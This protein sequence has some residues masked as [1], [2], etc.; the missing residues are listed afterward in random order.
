[1]PKK[2]QTLKQAKSRERRKA[3]ER[4]KSQRKAKSLKMTPKALLEQAKQQQTKQQEE[5]HLIEDIRLR[6]MTTENKEELSEMA[7]VNWRQELD[8]SMPLED[9][10]ASVIQ[11][12]T[13]SALYDAGR[14]DSAVSAGSQR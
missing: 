9:M 1:M 2:M 8:K 3:Q 12:L 7:M 5:S 4:R 11:L 13:S 14:A 10:R 6:V